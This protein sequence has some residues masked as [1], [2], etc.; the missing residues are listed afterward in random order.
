[1]TEMVRDSLCHCIMGFH[2]TA[3]ACT[4]EFPYIFCIPSV[5]LLVP[6]P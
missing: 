6:S 1:M 2:V 3:K 4:T 5:C